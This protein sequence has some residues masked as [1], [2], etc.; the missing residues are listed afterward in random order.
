MWRAGWEDLSS[1]ELALA[2]AIVTLLSD[3]EKFLFYS[4]RGPKRA[5]EFSAERVIERWANLLAE[6]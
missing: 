4:C 1:E 5:R 6:S 2:E 3:R